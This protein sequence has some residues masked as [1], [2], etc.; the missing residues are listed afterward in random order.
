[1]FFREGGC[2]GIFVVDIKDDLIWG[3][4]ECGLYGKKL[5]MGI[6][7]GIKWVYFSELSE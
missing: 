5:F 6:V 1:M 7:F 2:F 4:V 3:I